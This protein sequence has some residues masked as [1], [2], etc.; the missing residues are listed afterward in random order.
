MKRL[1]A[2]LMLAA[3]LGAWSSAPAS[4]DCD[5]GS[6]IAMSGGADAPWA[7]HIRLGPQDVPLNAPFDAAVVVCAASVPLPAR[8]TVDATMPAH[9]HGMNYEPRTAQIGAGHYQVRN[10]LFHMPGVWR[11][12]VTAYDGDKP[13]RYTHDVSVP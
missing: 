9:K 11:L 1:A 2:P 12:E 4:E 8:V 10:L 7:I 6:G 3:G 5:A 13:H